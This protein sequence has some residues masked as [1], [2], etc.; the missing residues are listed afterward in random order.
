[1]GLRNRGLDGPKFRMC[2]NVMAIGDDYWIGDDEGNKLLKVN[3]KAARIRDKFILE[4]A[5]GNELSKI[6]EKKLSS[7]GTSAS[8][9][10][11]DVPRLVDQALVGLLALE[12]LLHQHV[13]LGLEHAADAV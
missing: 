6:Q 1:M 10:S 11:A 3:G 2:E 13:V 9:Q 7:G 8:N 5:N 12:P 4:D